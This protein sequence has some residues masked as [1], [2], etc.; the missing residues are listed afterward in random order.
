MTD[1]TTHT[2]APDQFQVGCVVSIECVPGAEDD[3]VVL[4][5]FPSVGERLTLY[6]DEIR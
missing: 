4:V 3:A 1:R 5:R 2:D 6:V